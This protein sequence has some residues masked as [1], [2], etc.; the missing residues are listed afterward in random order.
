MFES[1]KSALF[2]K[3]KAPLASPSAAS[4]Q[5]RAAIAPAQYHYGKYPPDPEGFPVISVDDLVNSQKELI[6]TIKKSIR[7]TT[8]DQWHELFLD[9][10]RKYAAFVHLLPAS[11]NNHHCGVGGLFRHGLEVALGTI[12]RGYHYSQDINNP[13][14]LNRKLEERW[15]YACFIAGLL[16]DFGKPVTDMLVNSPD[17]RLRWSPTSGSL[18]KWATDNNLERYFVHHR[19]DRQDKHKAASA[20]FAYHVMS[21]QAKAYLEVVSVDLLQEVNDAI[22]GTENNA[23][24]VGYVKKSDSMSC[25]DDKKRNPFGEVAGRAFQGK[26]S[27]AL[28]VL[29]TIRTMISEGKLTPNKMGGHLWVLNGAVYLEWPVAWNKVYNEL[30][31]PSV[32]VP[33]DPQT[34][35]ELLHDAN[36]I[37]P[38]E[39]ANRQQYNTWLI[40]TKP[41]QDLGMP[42]Q[43]AISFT[44]AKTF[45]EVVPADAVGVIVDPSTMQQSRPPAAPVPETNP[46]PTTKAPE[47]P[48]VAAAASTAPASSTTTTAREAAPPAPPPVS[49]PQ[50]TNIPAHFLEEGPLPV[51]APGKAAA[52]N[53]KPVRPPG[54]IAADPTDIQN[55]RQRML[56]IPNNM[57]TYLIDIADSLRAQPNS[58]Y[59]K[60]FAILNDR[61]VI[62]APEGFGEVG[63]DHKAFIKRLADE[64]LLDNTIEGPPVK[65]SGVGFKKACVLSVSASR[66]MLKLIGPGVDIQPV[67]K[68]DPSVQKEAAAN[69]KAQ[70][71]AMATFSAAP[72][73]YEAPPLSQAE[74]EALAPPPSSESDDTPDPDTDIPGDQDVPS[75]PSLPPPRQKPAFAPPKMVT[76]PPKM[77]RLQIVPKPPV[78]ESDASSQAVE[79]TS[80]ESQLIAT[81]AAEQKKQIEPDPVLL[82]L[83]KKSLISFAMMREKR[84]D[85]LIEDEHFIHVEYQFFTQYL[86]HNSRDRD[87]F[88]KHHGIAKQQ[89]QLWG[90]CLVFPKK[91]FE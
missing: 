89:H 59:T 16:H 52:A 8:E 70:M 81:P 38:Y 71:E 66:D 91:L 47:V 62:A 75:K 82:E 44:H 13:P 45:Y 74:F 41:M 42:P 80:A 51:E 3:H 60:L 40:H 39:A 27:P 29:S 72:V 58:S 90:N 88:L 32:G 7:F 48:A 17:G 19:K 26:A 84:P 68:V 50:A 2:G 49:K 76:Q 78:D 6:A 14:S 54:K 83:R 25:E 20:A 5:G 56:R 23:P 79:A 24:L 46:P 86:N 85:Y 10:I 36:I 4:P 53:S 18:H 61:L 12:N 77:A 34:I 37:V 65:S 11:E 22:Y 55:I 63:I 31:S 43:R 33:R 57:G 30:Y 28:T 15:S 9:A 64:N 67:D 73:S 21:D 35:L 87:V 69:N 1:I